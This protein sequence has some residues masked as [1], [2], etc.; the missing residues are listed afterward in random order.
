MQKGWSRPKITKII[1]VG[2]NCVYEHGP[3]ERMVY[4]I[5]SVPNKHVCW[6]YSYHY[7]YC[8]KSRKVFVCIYTCVL[9]IVNPLR[10]TYRLKELQDCSL[11]VY[12]LNSLEKFVETLSGFSC[13]CRGEK[14]LASPQ[15]PMFA[16]IVKVF[17]F[18]VVAWYME[19]LVRGNLSHSK[20]IQVKWYSGKLSWNPFILDKQQNAQ[21]MPHSE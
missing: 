5:C 4:T 7:K 20:Q 8:Y 13:P 16:N 2:R 6:G 9:D 11:D 1:Q 3:P 18:W 10:T 14:W 21:D 15:Q 19:G 17:M 12:F